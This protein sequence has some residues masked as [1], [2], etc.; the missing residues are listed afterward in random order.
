M[1]SQFADAKSVGNITRQ[2]DSTSARHRIVTPTLRRIV[3]TDINQENKIVFTGPDRALK[4]EDWIK[5]NPNLHVKQYEFYN[6]TITLY[7]RDQE[8]E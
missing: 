1:F 5:N 6:E 8:D 7:L 4:A 3:M 2:T